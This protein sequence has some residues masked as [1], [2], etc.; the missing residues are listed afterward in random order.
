MVDGGKKRDSKGRRGVRRC[1][2]IDMTRV[3]LYV[4]CAM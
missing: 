3:Q 4:L 1:F 2:I